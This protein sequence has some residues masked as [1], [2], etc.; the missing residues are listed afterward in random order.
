[1]VFTSVAS[2]AAAHTTPELQIAGS[3]VRSGEPFLRKK[4][5]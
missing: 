5:S 2:N 1:M 4:R 3:E